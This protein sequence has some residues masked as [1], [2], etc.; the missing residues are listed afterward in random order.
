MDAGKKRH[1]QQTLL[2]LGDEFLIQYFITAQLEFRG[3]QILSRLFSMGHSL[4]LYV[5]AALLN[6]NK[7]MAGHDVPAL[8]A[9]YDNILSLSQEEVSVGEQLY[10]TALKNFDLGLF[11]KH[12]EALELYQAQ[13]FLKD[14]KYYITKDQTF[15]FPVRVSLLPINKRYLN[16]V[17]I[18]RQS[19]EE[20]SPDQNT[21]LVALVGKLGFENNPAELV[22]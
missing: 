1:S 3:N 5:K 20:K 8:I 2:T 22:I 18:L 4:E 9:E 16:I 15:I 14:L 12:Q 21:D 11:Q 6:H 7:L 17:K 19:I 10:T 13:Y